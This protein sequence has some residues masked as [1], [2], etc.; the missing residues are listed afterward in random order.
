MNINNTNDDINIA[1]TNMIIEKNYNN[2]C[3][4]YEYKNDSHLE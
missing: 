2:R 3:S 4:H 1:K